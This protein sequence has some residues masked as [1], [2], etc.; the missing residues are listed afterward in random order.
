MAD[1]WGI[2]KWI[3]KIEDDPRHPGIIKDL[4]DGAGLTRMGVTQRWYGQHVSAQFFT[5][6]PYQEAYDV[7]TKIYQDYFC[8]PLLVQNLNNQDLAAC[9][10][11]WSVNNKIDNAV[12]AL[13]HIVGAIEDGRMGPDTVAKANI[14]N[15]Q[16]DAA[17]A[18]AYRVQ[19]EGFYRANSDPRFIDGWIARVNRHYPN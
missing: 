2:A 4:H 3:V 7:A 6:M 15:Q 12:V 10:V 16:G 9:L 13:Q 14:F 18:A 17:L 19:W 5:D 8:G 11:S 1:S